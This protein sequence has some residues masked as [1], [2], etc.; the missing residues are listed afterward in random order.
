VKWKI[1]WAK[2]TLNDLDTLR[3]WITKWVNTDRMQ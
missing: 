2:E 3:E 1:E